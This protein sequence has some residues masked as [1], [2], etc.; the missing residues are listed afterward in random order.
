MDRIRFVQMDIRFNWF[1]WI[2]LDLIQGGN[3]WKGITWRDLRWRE[4]AWERE[5]CRRASEAKKGKTPLLAPHKVKL[6]LCY[7]E[8]KR[9]FRKNWLRVLSWKKWTNQE[10]LKSILGSPKTIRVS[11]LQ[12]VFFRSETTKKNSLAHIKTWNSSNWW[13]S[14]GIYIHISPSPSTLYMDHGM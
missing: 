8:K 7:P 11:I 2:G 14:V 3:Q 1:R 13:S 10:H 12:P 6:A 5:G 4:S 9:K